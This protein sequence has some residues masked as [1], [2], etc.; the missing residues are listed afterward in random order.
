MI[1]L[2]VNHKINNL[3]TVLCVMILEFQFF[4]LFILFFTFQVFIYFLIPL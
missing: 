2:M 3:E 1:Q 4:F